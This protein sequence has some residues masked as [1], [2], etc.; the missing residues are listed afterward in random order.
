MATEIRDIAMDDLGDLMETLLRQIQ[1]SHFEP[2]IVVYLETGAR[3]LASHFHRLTGIQAVPLTIQRSG[4]SGKARVATL[5]GLFPR[6]IQ[7]ALRKI[8]RII[9]SRGPNKRVLALAPELDLSGRRV[10]ILDDAADSGQSLLLARQWVLQSGGTR[11]QLRVAV[12]A[13]TQPRAKEIVDYWI[14]NQLCR[15]PWSSDSREREK[16]L[17]VYEQSAPSTATLGHL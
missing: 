10:L 15:F 2:D 13:V 16:Y 1:S 12:V 3:L 9:V 14:Y 6:F 5:L 7:D 4:H 11:D 8:E 17:R